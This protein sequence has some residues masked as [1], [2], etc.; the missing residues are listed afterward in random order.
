M[1]SGNFIVSEIGLHPEMKFLKE[2]IFD[3]GGYVLTDFDVNSESE[4]YGACSF[5]IDG[6]IVLF[7]VS[8]ITPTKTG[9]FVTIWQRN[10]HGITAPY[11]ISDKFDFIVIASRFEHNLGLFIFPK[12]V[13]ADMGIV[14][15]KTKEGRRGIRVYPPWDVPG[16]KQ[17]EMT[18]RWQCK[19]FIYIDDAVDP[20][21]LKQ[22]LR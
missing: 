4:E 13:L 22:M 14:A 2:C 15:A 21:V 19:Y 11:S 7:R 8:K 18:Q 5:A 16:S 1:D 6:T 12:L 20:N 9:Q 10:E 3:K 17:G